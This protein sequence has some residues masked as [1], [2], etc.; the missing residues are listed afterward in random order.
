MKNRSRYL[1]VRV[2]ACLAFS[3]SFATSG[4]ADDDFARKGAY[5]EWAASYASFVG[6]EDAIQKTAGSGYEVTNG[7]AG[8][9]AVGYRI[10]PRVAVDGQFTYAGIGD[11][12]LNNRTVAQ[13]EHYSVLVNGRFYALTGRIQPYAIAGIGWQYAEID[14][15]FLPG[16]S[17]R[18][19]GLAFR[20]GGGADLYIT[21]RLAITASATYLIGLGDVGDFDTLQ[22]RLGWMF[23]F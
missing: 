21:R 11:V 15:Q 20:V 22:A 16:M 19:S 17:H 6:L 18:N 12:K 9:V 5:M 2:G 3:L 8:D 1:I 13:F 4:S 23:R 7:V 10:T 14:E